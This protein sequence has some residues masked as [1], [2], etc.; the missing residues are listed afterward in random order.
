MTPIGSLGEWQA[1]DRCL[2]MDDRG[3]DVACSYFVVD[4]GM[5]IPSTISSTDVRLKGRLSCHGGLVLHADIVLER[6]VRD[7]V[8]GLIYRYQTQFADLPR[9]RVLRCDND[10]VYA[11]EG[12]PDAFHKHVFSMRTWKE[13]NVVHI[14]RDRFPNLLEV[15]DELYA[16][17]LAH[18][19]D[20]LIYP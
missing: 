19:D 7:R 13:I 9:R 15:I 16:W 4:P 11:R 5:I 8:R 14:G 17:W 2:S 20:P 10:H 3:I 6:D 1:L 18:R 12:H